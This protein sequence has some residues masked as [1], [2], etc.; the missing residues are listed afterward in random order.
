MKYS[1]VGSF[2]NGE[3]A[4]ILTASQS[5]FEPNTFKRHWFLFPLLILS[6]EHAKF[7]KRLR[8]LLRTTAN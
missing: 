1:I 7:Q 3:N 5:H 6:D 2:F 8:E 4:V